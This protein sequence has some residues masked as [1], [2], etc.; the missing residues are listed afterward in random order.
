MKVSCFKEKME[1]QDIVI[2]PL[3]TNVEC[4]QAIF[5]GLIKY[6]AHNNPPYKNLYFISGVI[7]NFLYD[8]NLF[9]HHV[10]YVIKNLCQ[11]GIKCMPSGKNINCS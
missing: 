3:F 2:T 10:Q 8:Q 5:R 7:E 6:R 11:A 9:M 1:I 4:R